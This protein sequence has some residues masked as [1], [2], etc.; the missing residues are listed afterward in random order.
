MSNAGSVRAGRAF[1]EL[2]GDDSKLQAVLRSAEGRLKAWG[3]SIGSVGSSIAMIG[4]AIA[5][6]LALLAKFASDSQETTNK[7]NQLFGSAAGQARNFADELGRSVGRSSTDIQKGMSAYQ[8]FFVGM[9]FG[10]DEALGLSQKLAGLSLDFASFH[11]IADDEAMGRFISALSGSSEVLDQFG[12]N[13][14][15]AAID[16]ELLR[17]GIKETAATANEA[18]KALARLNIIAG[19]M[20]AQGA[21][22]DAARTA[23]S[24]ANQLKALKASATE[25]ATELGMALLPQ[26]TAI[27]T[28]VADVLKGVAGWAK[29]N[30][31]LIST[32]GGVAIKVGLWAAGIGGAVFVIGKLIS[33]AGMAITAVRGLGTAMLFLS[34]NPLVMV[35]TAIGLVGV[36]LTTMQSQSAAAATETGKLADEVD[37]LTDSL[38]KARGK[39]DEARAIDELRIQYLGQLSRSTKLS[40]DQMT[41][42]QGIIAELTKRYGNLGLSIDAAASRLVGFDVAQQRVIKGMLDSALA[43]VEKAISERQLNI[44]RLRGRSDGQVGPEGQALQA[45]ER[46]MQVTKEQL[47]VFKKIEEEEKRLAELQ[48]RRRSLKSGDASA[49]TT[50]DES[51]RL[52]GKMT[53][54]QTGKTDPKEA[55]AEAKRV[56]DERARAAQDQADAIER[57]AGMSQQ[58]GTSLAR[59]TDEIQRQTDERNKLLQKI[60]ELE[61]AREGGPRAGMLEWIDARTADTATAHIEAIRGAEKRAADEAVQAMTERQQARRDFMDDLQAQ[62]AGLAEEEARARLEAAKGTGG[63]GPA[64]DALLAATKERARVE[65]EIWKAR[66]QREAASLFGD[67][68]AALANAMA[69][70]D[71]AGE[72][73]KQVRTATAKDPDVTKFKTEG[74]FSAV[75]AG[76][77]GGGTGYAEQTAKNTAAAAKALERIEREQRVGGKFT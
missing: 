57:L 43:D 39:G 16:E 13:I 32:V 55:E 7:F 73:M 71:Q 15:Q 36:G 6:P 77:L 67:D 24:F 31:G 33:V 28:T 40:G 61:M 72:A 52:R 58:A 3:S 76:L 1:V 68:P 60:R 63:E 34:A 21:T 12:V 74:T 2:A 59:E 11:N 46:S 49:I 53:F 26:M 70:I 22:G 8:A 47:E 27:V 44:D 42:A 14:K 51:A 20:G 35:I 62:A 64:A 37:R 18:D 19:A 75:A 56:A 38:D 66:Q 9:G 17:M 45:A 29:Q 5:S 30:Q 48:A 54:G 41:E 10:Q 25:S 65:A 69:Q 4:S 23:G 50:D